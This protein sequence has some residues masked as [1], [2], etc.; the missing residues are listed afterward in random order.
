MGVS[1]QSEITTT[2][3][4]QDIFL[5]FSAFEARWRGRSVPDAPQLQPGDIVG[6]GVLIAGQQAG[7]FRIELH[8]IEPVVESSS[9]SSLNP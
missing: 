2:G 7:P 4:Q 8:R 5:P 3:S 6:V 1:Y 9:F